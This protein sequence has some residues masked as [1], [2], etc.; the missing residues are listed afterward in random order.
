MHGA[1]DKLPEMRLQGRSRG[2][3]MGITSPSCPLGTPHVAQATLSLLMLGQHLTRELGPFALAVRLF[4]SQAS[5]PEPGAA[6]PQP[7]DCTPSDRRQAGR[8]NNLHS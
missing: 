3:E 8:Q 5:W 2:D 4:V 7:Q 6:V 1:S